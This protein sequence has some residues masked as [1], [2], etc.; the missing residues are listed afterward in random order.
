MIRFIVTALLVLPLLISCTNS[1]GSDPTT[2][3]SCSITSSSALFASDRARDVRQC[4]DGVSYEER[5]LAMNWCAAKVNSY[6]G[7][8]IFGHSIQYQLASTNCP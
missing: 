3:S 1:D 5:S 2:Y 7:R 8:Y 6:M 4:W